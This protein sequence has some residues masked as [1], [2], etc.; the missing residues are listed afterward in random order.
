MAKRWQPGAD[1]DWYLI[2]IDR[3]K[4]I[5]L[6][7]LLL[8][9][10]GA[11]W[12]FW[13]NQKT[14]PKTKAESAMSDARQALNAL[15]GSADFSSHRSEFNRAQ[16]KLDEAGTHFRASH[17]EQAYDVAVESQTISRAAVS[18]G[19]DQTSDAQFLTVEGDVQYQKGA[20]G[21]WK[22]ADGRT[23][24]VNGDWVKTGSNA[25]AELIFSSGTLYTVGANAL[26]EIYSAVNP[27][28]SRKTN[29]VQMRVG[30]V[31]IATTTDQST[32]RTPGTQVVVESRSTTQVGVDRSS[33]TSI[34]S[35]RGATSVAPEKGG[36]AIQVT[37][38]EMI[39]A[40]PA[41]EI[42]PVKKLAM[43]P[44]LMSPGDNQVFQLTPGLKVQMLWQPQT[45]ASAYV[46]QVSRSRLFS[47]QEINKR[48]T[49]TAAT[50]E[51][52]EEG[53]FYWRVASVGP[54]GDIGPFSPFRRFRVS[55]GSKSAG[56]QDRT[57]PMLRMKAPFH[58]GGQFYTIAGATEPGATVFINDEEVDVES[59]GAFQKLVAFDRVGRNVVVVKAVDPAGNQ[60]VESQIVIVEE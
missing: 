16:Q 59:G 10:G 56:T 45:G 35:T 60:K 26:L 20:A 12:W 7:L 4:Q 46:L 33:Q 1:I 32:I 54:D 17:F 34:V 24:L 36:A 28:T 44:P 25:S 19:G 2:S 42:S 43:P 39:S 15:A 31:E 22:D 48:M 51:V 38:G 11:G 27:A 18:G 13:Y 8:G 53:S 58:V 6:V 47:T 55:G 14:N 30:S 5:G 29:A 52:T 41:G 50:A 3:L 49:K 37:S 40:T 23:A 21:E 9:L 57:P